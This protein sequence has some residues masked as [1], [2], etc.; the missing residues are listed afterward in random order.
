MQTQR[1]EGAE[2]D[3][4]GRRAQMGQE[5]LLGAWTLAQQARETTTGMACNS[6]WREDLPV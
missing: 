6:P 2:G 3:G 4:G 1:G 5:A